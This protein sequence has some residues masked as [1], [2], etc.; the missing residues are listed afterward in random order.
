MQDN[1]QRTRLLIQIILKKSIGIFLIMLAFQPLLWRM[2]GLVDWPWA[3]VIAAPAALVLIG[4]GMVFYL[5]ITIM[6]ENHREGIT[7]GDMLI[8]VYEMKHGGDK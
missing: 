8:Q 1:K 5:V 4:I 6:I 7:F 2:F 3:A